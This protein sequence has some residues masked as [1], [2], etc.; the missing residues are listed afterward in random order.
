MKLE[1][2]ALTCRV[3]LRVTGGKD[4]QCS[5]VEQLRQ[6][7]Q[8]AIGACVTLHSDLDTLAIGACV[9]LHTDLDTLAKSCCTLQ[10]K[11]SYLLGQQSVTKQKSGC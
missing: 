5:S 8:L 11:Q 7:S 2:K 3:G 10:T 9:T 1:I 4:Q 6:A